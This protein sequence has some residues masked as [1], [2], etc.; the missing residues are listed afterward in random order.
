MS[1]VPKA[2]PS[3]RQLPAIG[4]GARMR[5]L[6]GLRGL[7]I[8]LV[9]IWHYLVTRNG[10]DPGSLHYL[11][12]RT[13]SFAWG[14]VD[15]FF[16]LSGFLIG[17]ILIDSRGRDDFFR[18]FYKRRIARL[19]PLYL[20]VIA[21]Y[22]ITLPAAA[23]IDPSGNSWLYYNADKFPL[24]SY[25]AYAQ[26]FYM[27]ANNSFGPN[28]LGDTWSLA[29]EEQFYLLVPLV[30]YFVP[31]RPLP[32]L[33]AALAV[34]ALLF[35]NL[36][37]AAGGS[38]IGTYVL[39]PARSEGLLVGLLVACIYRNPHVRLWLKTHQAWLIA[40]LALLLCGLAGFV[41][42]HQEIY[43]PFTR[44][45]GYSYLPLVAAAVLL[46]A[47]NVDWP[48]VK[49]CFT[50]AALVELGTISYAVYLL[51]NPV[52]ALATLTLL[53][54][55]QRIDNLPALFVAL[56]SFALTV[57]LARLSWRH[58]EKPFIDLAHRPEGQQARWLSLLQF[59]LDPTSDSF[60]R[61]AGVVLGDL[62]A[63]MIVQLGA[64][65]LA[66][67]SQGTRFD[68]HDQVLEPPRLEVGVQFAGHFGH[69]GL[70]GL[71]VE[72]GCL[73][74]RT[75]LA[76]AGMIAPRPVAA[77]LMGRRVGKL[78]RPQLLEPGGDGV[79]AILQDY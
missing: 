62:E 36:Y 60:R 53:D 9:V 20:V 33:F 18:R 17:G 7:A 30:V 48:V 40:A 38:I 37:I 5:E 58:L 46:V 78:A 50:N 13:F 79:A 34:L 26:N 51:H 69:E 76:H 31:V 11:F 3:D 4:A 44:I 35:R 55:N 21:L 67:M 15:L 70:F 49:N 19:M 56:A 47:L 65:R 61:L 66:Q 42:G 63:H 68:D 75:G 72:V 71:G 74:R 77:L 73:H 52:R 22:I 12:N 32:C 64:H 24:W 54:G 14:G 59:F 27:A 2:C 25:L 29:I 23:I 6:D 57:L 10:P 41:V 1:D 28:W 39:L 8:L 16:V 45:L 43:S